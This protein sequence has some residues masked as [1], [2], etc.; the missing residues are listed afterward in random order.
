[1]YPDKG[2]RDKKDWLLNYDGG[3]VQLTRAA[4]QLVPCT[5]HDRESKCWAHVRVQNISALHV[6][7]C[8]MERAYVVHLRSTQ[9]QSSLFHANQS[10]HDAHLKSMHSQ[11]S[12][13]VPYHRLYKMCTCWWSHIYTKPITCLCSI[14]YGACTCCWSHISIQNQSLIIVPYQMERA[15]VADL[16]YLYKTSH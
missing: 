8:S 2:S 4:L 13:S 7:L 16:I 9:N 14:P 3:R 11:S 12:V 6:L 15:R 1:M 10:V 5:N